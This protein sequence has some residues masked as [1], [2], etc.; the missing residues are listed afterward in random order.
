MTDTKTTAGK[1]PSNNPF[2]IFI[3]GLRKGLNIGLYSLLPNVLMAFVLTHILRLFGVMDFLGEYCGGVMGLF[4]LPG[5]AITVLLATWLSCGAGVGVAASL[6]AHNTLSPHDITILAPAFI[7]L[8]S[9]IQYMGRLLGV[10][11][12]PKKYWPVL[13]LNSLV[14]TLMAM[15]CMKLFI[16]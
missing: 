2:D 9:Q 13:M 6:A 8:A 15:I 14:V 4:G 10:A 3:V 12:V 7:L 1:K 5:E 16:V 11:D